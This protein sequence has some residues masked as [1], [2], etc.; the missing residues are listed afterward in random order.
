M[1]DDMIADR[2]CLETLGRLASASSDPAFL[3]P[4][5]IQSDGTEGRWGSWCGFLIAREIVEAV[6]VP[7]EELFW[8]AE[9]TEYCQWRI[10]KAGFARR[11]SEDA[12]VYHDAVRR[13][14][15]VPPWKYYYE[16][17]NMLYLHL[18]V[19]HRLGWYPRNLARLVGRAVVRQRSNRIPC[20][21]A[22]ARGLVDG[23]AGRLGKRYPVTPLREY[24]TS[25]SAAVRDSSFFLG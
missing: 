7:M 3:F 20:L 11:V 19:M 18:H 12:V 4:V 8:W 21:W 13:G 9:D 14:K 17:R 23:A 10:P 15:G 22:M 5:A 1:D 24:V 16:A 25:G 2:T 6:G